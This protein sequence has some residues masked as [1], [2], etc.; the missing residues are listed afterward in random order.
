MN[1]SQIKDRFLDYL[2]VNP[3]NDFF[4]N[5]SNHKE[6]YIEIKNEALNRKFDFILAACKVKNI[7]KKDIR[8]STIEMDDDLKNIFVR[9]TLLKTISESYK[10]NIEKITLYPIEIKSDRDK[11][12]E[13]LANQVIE[14]ILSFGR[15]I[16]ILDSKHASK[17]IKHGLSRIL[18]STLI[19]YFSETD[20]FVVINR[21]D[22]VYS[23]SLLNVNKMHLIRTLKRADCQ[24]NVTKLY[25]N[26]RSLQSIHQKLIYNQIFQNGQYLLEDEVIFMKE[27]SSLN[28]KTNVKKEIIKTIQQYKNYKITDFTE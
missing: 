11:L 20:K 19:G 12:D 1:E 5:T 9:S 22:R 10:M 21:H 24:I 17:I 4:G 28:L 16:I 26:L 2:N 6:K 8:N 25:N 3:K 7:K 18:P 14:A 13:R 15:S 27:L 23:D